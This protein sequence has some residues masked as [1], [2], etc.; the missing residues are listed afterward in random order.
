MHTGGSLARIVASIV[1][2]L[3]NRVRIVATEIST[4]PKHSP[5]GTT[6]IRTTSMK[7]EFADGWDERLGRGSESVLQISFVVI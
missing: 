1:R 3:A 4:K 7:R 2:T 6:Q 5:R